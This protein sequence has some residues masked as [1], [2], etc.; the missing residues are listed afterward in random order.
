M[1]LC[2]RRRVAAQSAA[3]AV[4]REVDATL[5]ESILVDAIADLGW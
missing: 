1:P 2:V 5:C 4:V 3:S